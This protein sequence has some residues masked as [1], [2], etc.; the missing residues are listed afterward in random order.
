MKDDAPRRF[1]AAWTSAHVQARMAEAM[2]TARAL[3]TTVGPGTRT[4]SWPDIIRSR[5]ADYADDTPRMRPAAPSPHD[6]A[7]LEEVERW[8]SKWLSRAA[9]TAAGMVDDT[10][11][12]L[13]CRSLGWT[14]ARIGRARKEA[15]AIAHAR[16]IGRPRLPGGNSRPSLVTIERKGLSYLA[17]QLNLSGKPLD[18]EL[19]PPTTDPASR[20]SGPSAGNVVV[21]A[22]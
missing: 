4:T 19:T 13:T 8:V 12:V 3:I 22:A 9:C 14:Y 5:S 15:W 6:L 17:T 7:R 10:G 20:R 16:D 11:W 21:Q 18:P 1:K 2:G